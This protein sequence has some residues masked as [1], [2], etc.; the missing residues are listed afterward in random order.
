MSLDVVGHLT[1]AGLHLQAPA[2]IVP[3]TMSGAMPP[4]PD[5]HRLAL[6]LHVPL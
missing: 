2:V 1:S 5:P 6:P 3:V 4:L